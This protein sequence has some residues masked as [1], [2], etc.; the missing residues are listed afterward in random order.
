[1]REL[2]EELASHLE[3][4][5]DDNLRAGMA[6]AEARRRALLALGGVEQTRLL[7]RDQQG[8]PLLDTLAQDVRL[9]LRM[10]R[11]GPAFAGVAVAV[12][13]LGIGANTVMFG[14]VN[15]LLLRPL[16]YPDAGRLQRVQTVDSQLR[17]GATAVPDFHEDRARN[18]S[19]DGL[20]AYY[21]GP[22]DLTGG[23][24]PE[25]VRA[26]IVSSE[27]LDVLRTPAALGRG[28]LPGDERWG[29][30]RV[31]LLTDAFWRRRFAADP[32]IVGRP[33][34]HSAEPFSIVGV[35]P[36]GFSFLGFDVQALVPMSFAPGDN[37]NSHNNYFLTML[38]RLRRDVAPAAALADLNAI[39]RSIILEH[40]ENQGTQ[41]GMRPLQ[42]ALVGGVRPALLV[43]F[44]AVGFVLLIA[45]ANLANLLLARAAGRR[46][47]IALRIALGAS[48]R[49]LLRQMLTESVLLALA[50]SAL[51]LGLAWLSVRILNSLGQ[52][53]LPRSGDIRI[54]GAVLAFTAL[55]A[56]ATG[57]LFGLAP[58]LRSVDVDPAGALKD[59]ARSTGDPRGR[60][61]RSG[62]VV[63]EVALSLVLLIGAGLMTKS[64][65]GLAGVDAGFDARQVLTAQLSLPRQRYVDA[66]LERRFSRLAYAS[67]TRFFDEVVRETRA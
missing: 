7:Y 28:F 22:F 49:R 19:F 12:L 17:D 2:Q 27:F 39:S 9:G 23:A 14:V 64:L 52:A 34:T 25:R 30:H 63:A 47:E 53:L 51:A 8:L 18:R 35:L 60:R 56:V 1:E 41:I 3:M 48:R 16:P 5:V 24:E 26:L 38:G 57:V 31:A 44:G 33:I 50:G 43:L 10:M 32:S 29:E 58:A 13:A 37:L 61:L 4:H 45:C 65:R 15:A 46:R 36:R 21:L 20:A 67:A 54:D 59:G 66:E 55:V 62:L 42:Q 11:R 6:P 40:P